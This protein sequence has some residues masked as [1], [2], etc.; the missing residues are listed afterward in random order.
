MGWTRRFVNLFR[1]DR[2]AAEFEEEIA[3][4]LEERTRELA[5]RGSAAPELEARRRFGNTLRQCEAMREARLIGWMDDLSRDLR[6]AVRLVRRNPIMTVAAAGALA[7]AIGGTAAVFS[8]LDAAILRTLPVPSPDRLVRLTYPGKPLPSGSEE[9]DQFSYPLFRSLRENAGH[10]ATLFAASGVRR[11]DAGV[12][13]IQEALSVQYVSG[14]AFGVLGVQPALGRLIQPYDDLTPGAHP[15][16]VLSYRCWQ[17]HFGASPEALGRNLT[18]AGTE[19]EIVGVAQP[20][21]DG[22]E[23]GAPAD[24][25]A[26]TMMMGSREMVTER[27]YR[28]FVVF[29]R[30]RFGVFPEQLAARLQPVFTASL[31]E[32]IGGRW[33]SRAEMPPQVLAYLQS[34]LAARPAAH[35]TS[36]FRRR[37]ST[38]LWMLAGVAGLVLM[39]AC[40]NLA[41]L[42]LAHASARR[43]EME[44]RVALGASRSRLLRQVFTESALIAALGCAGGFVLAIASAPALLA[45]LDRPDAPARLA[46]GPDLRVVA[47]VL[48]AGVVA[49]LFLGA[50]P[51][52]RACLSRPGG[53]VRERLEARGLS[54]RVFVFAQVALS[55]V[56]L[57]GSSMFIISLNNL[58]TLPAGFERRDLLLADLIVDGPMPASETRIRAAWEDLRLRI[59]GL[60]GVR[61]CAYSRWS[62]LS[63]AR[64]TMPLSR[65][66]ESV[67]AM[68]L[69]V[70]SGFFETMGTKLQKG[71]D[72]LPGEEEREVIVNH[73]LARFW[74]GNVDPVGKQF[75]YGGRR[76]TVVGLSEDAR[77]YSL[78]ESAPPMI[79]LPGGTDAYATYAIR[80]SASPVDMDAR[81]R[82]ELANSGAPLR[83]RRMRTQSEEVADTMVREHVMARLS[84]FFSFIAMVL[85][86]LGVHGVLSCLVARRT[87]EIGVRSALGAPRSR[88]ARAVLGHVSPAM[89]LGLI[90]GGLLTAGLARFTESMLFG[91]RSSS[92]LPFC[93]AGGLLV[94]A[95]LAAGAIPVVR[96]IRVSPSTALREC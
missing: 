48:L 67:E 42:M 89:I 82:R 83:V 96:A 33:R 84:S 66:G 1:Q 55:F 21:F 88:I 63:G 5:E 59:G 12:G 31:Y 35:G 32:E 14:E 27:G 40:C 91:L 7:L 34:K 58:L 51:A 49:S 29:G 62:L 47:F 73:A 90:A 36:G 95:G 74:F 87:H 85:A 92:P 69:P 94:L 25:W 19:L 30:L 80:T 75:P 44:M 71:R 72:F 20:G 23:V 39:V 68:I 24:L 93:L 50:L 17:R 64:S 6:H 41:N 37:F 45:L 18:L 38:A 86:C 79:Y 54:G 65:S 70:S 16:V 77:Y 10:D 4:H 28:N 22:T 81:L 60:P 11:T 3:F 78:R 52:W 9:A 26:P 76:L 15:V 13:S 43:G 57:A 53:S 56:L 61:G 8:V 2:L 46:L